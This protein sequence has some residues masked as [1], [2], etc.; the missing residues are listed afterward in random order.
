MVHTKLHEIENFVVNKNY[1]NLFFSVLKFDHTIFAKISY[2]KY[3]TELLS[4][5]KIIRANMDQVSEE[6]DL[7]SK[8]L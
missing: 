3:V 6:Y 8:I 2:N 7:A 4:C 5:Y 1:L